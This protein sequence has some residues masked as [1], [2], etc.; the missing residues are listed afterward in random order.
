MPNTP[1]TL[2][3]LFAFYHDR[4][5]PLY[6]AVQLQNQLPVEVLFELN[7]ALDHISRQYTY[8]EAEQDVV[9][10]A[11]A[12]LKRS[13][14][15][16]FKLAVK[17]A[18]DQ[19]NE[20]RKVDTSIIDNGDYDQRLL[21]LYREIHEGATSARRNEGDCRNDDASA[22]K[23]FEMWEPVYGNC[24]RLTTEFYQHKHVNWAKKIQKHGAWVE[25]GIGFV[26]GIVA[27]IIASAIWGYATFES[28]SGVKA[29]EAR[30]TS[31][32]SHIVP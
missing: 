25:R 26:L 8:S 22:I 5:K 10:R 18:I 19:F 2:H 20:L 21:R 11:Y 29:A 1:K 31:A 4:V 14:L 15:D 16:I 17:D 12:H 27:S 6:S 23:A 7:A 13:C 3:E 28:S 24:V 9:R 32:Q 30:P